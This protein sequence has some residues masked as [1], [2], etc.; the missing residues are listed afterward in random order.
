MAKVR[1]SVFLDMHLVVEVADVTRGSS[2]RFENVSFANVTLERGAVVGTSLN[3]DEVGDDCGLFYEAED[4]E[5]YDVE[6]EAV[7]VGERGIFREEFRIRDDTMSDCLF[8]RAGEGV[9]LPGCPEQSAVYRG[10]M[11]DGLTEHLRSEESEDRVDICDC[12][13]VDCAP[14]PKDV[15]ARQWLYHS[16]NPWLSEV[17][18]VCIIPYM[19]VRL[20]LALGSSHTVSTRLR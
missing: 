5:A 20:V 13:L 8:L 12:S 1:N 19:H 15:K 18:R 17:M 16:D 10:R 4:D 7:P 6:A 14:T 11:F 9:V 2:V 3:D